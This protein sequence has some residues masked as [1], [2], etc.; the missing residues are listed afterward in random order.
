MEAVAVGI[1]WVEIAEVEQSISRFGER[2]LTRVFTEGERAYAR[3]SDAQGAARLAARFAAKEAVIKV[4]RPADRPVP[5]RDIEVL[6]TASGA[7]DI[8]LTGMALALAGEA[9]IDRISVSLTHHGN[10]AA[11]VAA[12]LRKKDP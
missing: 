8:K 1:D 3:T 11:A 5:W 9:G 4:L 10:Q 6:K 2:Y 7:C 12:A